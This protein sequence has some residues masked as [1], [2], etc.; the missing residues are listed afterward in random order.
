[1]VINACHR[2]ARCRTDRMDYMQMGRASIHI[3]AVVQL[4][5]KQ[6]DRPAVAMI[7]FLLVS[8]TDYLNE[9]LW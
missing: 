1:M 7:G 9:Q 8:I 3:A 2:L 4:L 5:G 6:V